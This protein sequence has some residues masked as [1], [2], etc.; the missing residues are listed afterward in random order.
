MICACKT[1]MNISDMELWVSGAGQEGSE[2]KQNG[3]GIPGG[4]TLLLLFLHLIKT[5]NGLLVTQ[6]VNLY[7]SCTTSDGASMMK[8]SASKINMFPAHKDLV[9]QGR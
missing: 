6:M 8:R 2:H 5:H 4:I 3:R 9:F 7:I 1:P